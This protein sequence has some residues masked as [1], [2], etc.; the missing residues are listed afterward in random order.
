MNRNTIDN[1]LNFLEEKEGKEIP[2]S[3]LD[4]IEKLKLIEKLENHIGGNQFKHVNDLDLDGSNIRKLPD[5]L[6][7]KGS[8]GLDNCKQLTELPDNLHVGYLLWLVRTN[9]SEI[10]NNL[11]VH[12]DLYINDT[13]LANKYT[14]QQIRDIVASTGG[15]IKGQIIRG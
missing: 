10:P 7:V 15:K 9:I 3:W 4:S 5:N 12:G 2:E 1:I 6:Y 11:Y 13:P 14:N 8:L